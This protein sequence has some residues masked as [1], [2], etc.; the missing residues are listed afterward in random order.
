MTVSSN[1]AVT[2]RTPGTTIRLT[3]LFDADCG[4][5]GRTAMLIHG[6]DRRRA[7]RIVPLQRAA[8]VIQGVPPIETL[9][10]T[11]HVVDTDGRWTTGGSAWIRI[12]D[13]IPALWWIGRVARIGLVRPLIEPAYRWVAAHRMLLGRMLGAKA[14]RYTPPEASTPR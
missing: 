3:M 5:C 12:M 1:D 13:E 8:A 4:F 2:A 14:C 7:I 9:V 11:I 6:L 10:D